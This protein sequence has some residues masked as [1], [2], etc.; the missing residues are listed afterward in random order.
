ME[1]QFT[2]TS[3]I[4]LMKFGSAII[5]VA[6]ESHSSDNLSFHPSVAV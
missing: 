6:K 2:A 1:R 4:L 5:Q 3:I